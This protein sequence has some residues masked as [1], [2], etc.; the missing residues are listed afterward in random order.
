MAK[1]SDMLSGESRLNSYAV[2]RHG[3]TKPADINGPKSNITQKPSDD[4]DRDGKPDYGVSRELS[5]DENA[6]TL[7]K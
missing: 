3:G 6:S 5:E 1:T 7:K 2:G 4:E